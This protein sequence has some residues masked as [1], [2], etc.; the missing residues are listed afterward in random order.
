MQESA[1]TIGPSASAAGKFSAPTSSTVP[2]SSTT[3]VPPD[4]RETCRALG[5]NQFLLRQRTGHG[6]DRDD[7]QKR[8]MSIAMPSVVLYHGVLAVRPAKALPLLPVQELK[9]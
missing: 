2:M 7:H 3:N 8:P 5:R 4:N 9:A 6:H 1:P